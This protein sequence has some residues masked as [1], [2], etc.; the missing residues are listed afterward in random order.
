[1]SYIHMRKKEPYRILDEKTG[2]LHT[3]YAPGG[4]TVCYGFKEKDAVIGAA[5]C[6]PAE[7]NWNRRVACKI[8]KERMLT[9]PLRIEGEHEFT[10]KLIAQ[11][12]VA[13]LIEEPEWELSSENT[14]K[15]T[16]IGPDGNLIRLFADG[17]PDVR[18]IEEKSFFA[19]TAEMLADR[20]HLG[21][22]A[23]GWV[24]RCIPGWDHSFIK[25]LT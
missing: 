24:F 6:S 18:K 23:R 5:F 19:L 3:A 12:L 8:S 7:M 11:V 21:T 17:L 10:P 4:I 20:S 9:N 14:W 15:T 25:D 22:N 2:I 1:M 13:F 16:L